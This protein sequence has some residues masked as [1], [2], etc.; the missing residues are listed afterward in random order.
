[1]KKLIDDIY[2]RNIEKIQILKAK[3]LSKHIY[4]HRAY[5]ALFTVKKNV[6]K[7]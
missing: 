6:K 3:N 4:K 5:M 2:I 7:F 1:M